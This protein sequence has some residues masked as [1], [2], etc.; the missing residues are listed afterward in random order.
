MGTCLCVAWVFMCG[1]CV[2]ICVSASLFVCVCTLC[3]ECVYMC[4]CEFVC[5]GV[6]V[7]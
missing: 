3:G 6:Y 1:E 2:Y 7:W 4:E 5:V